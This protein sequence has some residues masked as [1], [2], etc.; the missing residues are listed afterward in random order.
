M[1][2]DHVNPLFRPTVQALYNKLWPMKTLKDQDNRVH[3][4]AR[5]SH[6]LDIAHLALLVADLQMQLFR[7]VDF[8]VYAKE[9]GWETKTFDNVDW[10]WQWGE[11]QPQNAPME[12]EL[13]DGEI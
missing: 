4:L 7:K 12:L 6:E 10:P 13:P 5:L 1:G 2:D 3:I 9:R 11:Q 8:T